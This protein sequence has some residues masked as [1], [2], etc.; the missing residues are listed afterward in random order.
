MSNH[1]ATRKVAA[2][3]LAA[4]IIAAGVSAA[5]SAQPAPRATTPVGIGVISNF[6]NSTINQ[7]TAITAGPDGAL[8]FT[9]QDTSSIGRITTAGA[10]TNYANPSSS[11][12]YDITTGSDGA[13]WFTNLGNNV[14][15][16]ITTAGAQTFYR[17]P[18]IV[19][20]LEIAPG[21]DGALWVTN[22][23]NN[24]I[25]RITTAGA[26]SNYSD[27]SISN[28][29]GIAPGPDGDLWFTNPGNNSIDKITTAGVITHYSNPAISVPTEITAGP[30]GAMWFADN[31]NNSIGRITTAGVVTNYTS[32]SISGPYGIT[33]GSDGAMWFTNSGN[34]SIGRITTGP[35]I[36]TQ[37]I[38]F[39]STPPA[40][41]IV[42]GP[43]YAVTATG[44]ASGNPVV[45]SID[46]SASSVCT[47]DDT[48]VSFIG[49]GRCTIDANQAGDDTHG[50]APQVQQNV[51]VS[52]TAYLITSPSEAGTT[53]GSTFSFTVT[54]SGSPLPTITKKG[55]L[56]Q[57][58]SFTDNGDGT[59]TIGGTP[60]KIGTRHIRIRARFGTGRTK[61]VV[62][63]VWALTVS[64]G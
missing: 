31:G 10:V 19:G 13:L 52:A 61:T 36:S 27:P 45:F 44:G 1:T 22:N 62:T 55:R 59:A 51:T 41:A 3:A 14:I 56:P 49:P 32:S 16:R 64:A 15:G 8:W 43:T 29:D 11:I 57:G 47:I 4:L 30:D 60:S 18:T 21:S 33:A 54:T 40:P 20:P 28:V 38:T 39:T 26:V 25:G 24:S 2:G 5:A 48:T 7:P 46:P 42:G 17:D 12:T 35:S 50:A 23:G 53:A 9:N 34:N 37:T 63:Q 6:T 58:L